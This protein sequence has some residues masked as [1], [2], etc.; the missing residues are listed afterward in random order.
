MQY[1]VH[2]RATIQTINPLKSHVILSISDSDRGPVQ[3]VP[4][5]L[6]HRILRMTFDDVDGGSYN[7]DRPVVWFSDSQARS[8]LDFW[9]DARKAGVEE[10]YVHCN[11]GHSRSPAVAAALTR[12]EGEDDDHWFRSRT[13][14]RLVYR[15]ILNIWFNE[16]GF[17]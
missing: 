8:I 10:F 12:I 16:R 7:V 3:L 2:T 6:C 17:E 5:A 11:A 9:E 15:T 4:H 1:I 13:P 14:N